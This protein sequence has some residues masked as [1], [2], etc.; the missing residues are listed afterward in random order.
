MPIKNDSVQVLLIKI[1]FDQVMPI[2][3]VFDAFEYFQLLINRLR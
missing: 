3:K 2:K 1:D